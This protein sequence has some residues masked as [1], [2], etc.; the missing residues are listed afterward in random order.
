MIKK[1]IV[2]AMGFL[3][4]NTPAVFAQ[5]KTYSLQDV[6]QD[7]LQ[8]YPSLAARKK[9]IEEQE[10]KKELIKESFLPDINIQAQQSYGS[11]QNIPGSFFP[12]PGIYTTSGSNKTADNIPGSNIYSSALL[13]WNFMQF[14]RQQKKLTAASAAIR[15]SNTQLKQE[16]WNLLSNAS[17]F[18]FSA[19]TAHAALRVAKADTRRLAELLELLQSQANAGLRPGADTLLLKSSLLQSKAKE[20]D[21][22]ATL[23]RSMIRLGALM[24]NV[25][26]DFSIDTTIFN[27]FQPTLVGAKDVQQEHPYLEQMNARIQAAEADKEVVKK[28]IYPSV[29]LLAGVGVKGSGISTDGTMDKGLA[30]SWQNASGTYLAGIGLTWNFASLYQNKTKRAVADRVIA[31]AKADKEA[32]QIQLQAQYASSLAGWDEQRQKLLATQASLNASEEAY[33][34]YKVR[35]ESGLLNLI[36]LLQLQKNL[37][38]AESNY[39]TA[40]SAYWNE[41]LN[42]SETLGDPSLILTVIKP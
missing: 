34:L 25:K 7:V 32:V 3:L 35:Y 42:Q 26:S 30:G 23:K 39:V 29:G 27:R 31:T 33:A 19:L 16:E 11:I 12:L 9:A 6:W 28:E 40:V 8:H 17:R 24:G 36:E 5:S 1:I 38:E 10:L 18:Y 37:Q 4:L 22:S 21:F 2:P 14:G 20:H 15:V 41:L 13:Q